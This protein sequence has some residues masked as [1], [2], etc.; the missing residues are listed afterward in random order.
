MEIYA[1]SID[2]D[3]HAESSV[4][5]FKQVQNKMHWAAH[6]HTTAEVIYERADSEKENMGL[7]SWEHDEIRRSDVDVAKNYLTE[8]IVM[9]AKYLESTSFIEYTLLP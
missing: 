4:L 9:P 2:Y 1:T 5:F 3:P 8:T 7:T 6:R